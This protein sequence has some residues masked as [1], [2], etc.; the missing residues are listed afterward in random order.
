MVK[1]HEFLHQQG[2]SLRELFRLTD[3]RH[4]ALSELEN[5]KRQKLTL[6]T[7]KKLLMP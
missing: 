7:S 5:Q 4:A 2:I 1:I 3:I 6:I